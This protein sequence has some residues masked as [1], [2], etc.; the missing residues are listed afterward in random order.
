MLVMLSLLASIGCSR[1]KK[2]VEYQGSA[3]ENLPF[4]YRMTVQQGNIITESMVDRLE[5]GMTKAQ[6]RYLLGTPILVDFFQTDRWDYTYTIQ[7]GSQPMETRYL[8]LFFREDA[9][10]R[11]TGDLQPDPARA[12]TRDPEQMV[13]TVP[14]HEERKGFITRGLEAIGLERRD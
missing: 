11:I 7:R 10:T 12:Q 1:E 6:V 4:V 3:L 5:L 2:P 8:T 14:D 9:L 13:I